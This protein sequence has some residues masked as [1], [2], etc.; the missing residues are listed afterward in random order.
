VAAARS[1]KQRVL[2]MEK[3]LVEV[4]KRRRL[5]SPARKEGGRDRERWEEE[6]TGE[7]M[8]T[9][10]QGPHVRW[11]ISLSTSSSARHV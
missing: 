4:R 8:P 9:Y 11:N 1:N 6:E 3:E 2:E 10:E 5:Q 7:E